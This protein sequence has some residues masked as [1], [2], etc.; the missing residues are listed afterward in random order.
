[1]KKSER[2]EYL[3]NCKTLLE[4]KELDTNELIDMMCHKFKMQ[5]S[6]LEKYMSTFQSSQ[7]LSMTN[8]EK[9]EKLNDELIEYKKSQL[10]IL[11][12]AKDAIAD[13]IASDASS[14][15]EYAK[16][17]DMSLSTLTY[18]L[19]I[20]I[21]CEDSLYETYKI[22]ALEKEEF[23]KTKQISNGVEV[24]NKLQNGVLLEDGSIRDFDLIDYYEMMNI[25]PKAAVNLLK[26][27]ISNHQLVGLKIFS[28]RYLEDKELT[29]KDVSIKLNERLEINCQKDK[30]GIFVR[31]TGKV[32]SDDEKLAV[33]NYILNKRIPL[34]DGTYESGLA[35]VKKNVFDLDKAESE[36][37]YT[38]V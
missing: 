22:S 35:R 7:S 36:K 6:V 11:D 19:D 27:Y 4:Y 29:P 25:K 16:S 31:G 1:M 5:P 37:I 8:I 33:I 34:T 38:L 9:I 18:Y 26:K 13:Y 32:I 21:L 17:R 3:H 20:L 28:Q 10:Y 30:R 2:L 15:K 23:E 14:L 24:I 12:K